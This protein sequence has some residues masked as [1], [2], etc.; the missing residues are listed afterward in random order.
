M[1]GRTG[2]MA[3]AAITPLTLLPRPVAVAV[4][5]HSR[6]AQASSQAG[7]E[8]TVYGLYAGEPARSWQ[9]QRGL[10]RQ[11]RST[12]ITAKLVRYDAENAITGSTTSR[13]PSRPTT[14][15]SSP[16]SCKPLQVPRR[17]RGQGQELRRRLELRRL[18]PQRPGRQLLHGA[19]RGLRR[20]AVRRRRTASRSRR[21]RSCPA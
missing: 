1:R 21:P 14:T 19:D 12:P 17:H 3:A 6:V 15:R 10:R 11:H 13:S 18:R 16:S 9:H 2:G 5:S 4:R 20:P 8:I 7:G